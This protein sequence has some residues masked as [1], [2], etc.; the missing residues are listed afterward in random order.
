MTFTLKETSQNLLGS[1]TG[2]ETYT[3]LQVNLVR[4]FEFCFGKQCVVQLKRRIYR[5]WSA[6]FFEIVQIIFVVLG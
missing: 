3:K 5:F 6:F 2:S 1:E 4:L